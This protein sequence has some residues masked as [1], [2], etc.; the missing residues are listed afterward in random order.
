MRAIV[1]GT[2]SIAKRHLRNLRQL[3]PEARLVVVERHAGAVIPP[4]IDALVAE[5]YSDLNAALETPADLAVVA[6]PA[7]YHVQQAIALT[8]RGIPTLIE[9]PLGADTAE[10][11]PLLAIEA[12][13]KAPMLVG[14]CLRYHPVFQALEKALAD[15]VIGRVYNLRAEVGQYLPNWRPGTDYRFG[16]SAQKILGGGALMELSHELDLIR[17]L[18]G[19]PH[20]VTAVLARISELET[21]VDDVA[22][23]ITRHRYDG[24]EVVASVHL[25]LYRRVPRRFIYIDGDAG[26]LELDFVQAR[27]T[28]RPL[29]GEPS[30]VTAPESFAINDVYLDELRDL[31]AAHPKPRVGLR[32]GF[33]T[34][35]I[36][37][38]AAISARE[39]RTIRLG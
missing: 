10:C 28:H 32:D 3:F 20:A 22:E 1:T 6:T 31:T 27:L 14:Y 5:R 11:A 23:I 36:V 9:K 17:A 8:E 4:E 16:V 2:G 7:P 37:E 13:G 35:R 15:K 21:D 24:Q 26:S 25:D 29:G 38:A 19:T 12:A 30:F 39:E 33:E 18:L 34:M